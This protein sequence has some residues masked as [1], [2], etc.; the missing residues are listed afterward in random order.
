MIEAEKQHAMVSYV[1]RPAG[2]LARESNL[3]RLVQGLGISI[4]VAALSAAAVGFAVQ[5][6]GEQHKTIW[7][8]KELVRKG[9]AMLALQRN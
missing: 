3:R 4:D 2:V 1:L 8:N 6:D 7:E 5:G 9:K